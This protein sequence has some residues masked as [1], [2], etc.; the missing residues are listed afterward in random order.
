MGSP[1][2]VA[3]LPLPEALYCPRGKALEHLIKQRLNV[4]RC[5][6]RRDAAQHLQ[7]LQH[8]WKKAQSTLLGLLY[9]PAR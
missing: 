1:S 8:S 2:V 4:N 7:A 9:M 6:G 3:F 5:N